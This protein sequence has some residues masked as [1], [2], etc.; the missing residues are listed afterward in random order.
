[1]LSGENGAFPP[2]RDSC[3]HSLPMRK[4]G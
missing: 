4:C 1:M 3:I 2:R